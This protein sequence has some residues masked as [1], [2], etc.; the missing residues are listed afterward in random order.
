MVRIDPF[1]FLF[2]EK[3]FHDQ[4]S[5]YGSHRDGVKGAKLFVRSSKH[6]SG[7][8]LYNHDVLDANAKVIRFVKSDKS[9]AYTAKEDIIASE[10]VKDFLKDNK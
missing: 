10:N 3:L 7:V 8:F 2:S 4:G 6:L 5:L 9:G 1:N